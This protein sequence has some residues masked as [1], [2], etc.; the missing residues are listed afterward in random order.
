MEG[1]VGCEVLITEIATGPPFGLGVGLGDE[2][3]GK[4]ATP[5]EKPA[6]NLFFGY[7]VV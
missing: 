2:P 1:E 4:V 7:R 6:R 5:D 3:T